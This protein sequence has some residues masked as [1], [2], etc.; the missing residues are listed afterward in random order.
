MTVT[1]RES[2]KAAAVP[3]SK[4]VGHPPSGKVNVYV[5]WME[6]NPCAG[7]AI[8]MP[9]A[10][11]KMPMEYPTASR[12]TTKKV[13]HGVAELIGHAVPRRFESGEGEARTNAL[14]A[15]IIPILNFH[16]TNA[17]LCAEVDFEPLGRAGQT[18]AKPGPTAA[19]G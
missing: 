14:L 8:P 13:R 17:V 11:E 5:D 12:S 3:F 7:A 10:W 4:G 1:Y 16:T 6:K 9:F 18:V 2:P 19:T 15:A